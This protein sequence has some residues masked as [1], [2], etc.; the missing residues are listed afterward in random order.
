MEESI[1]RV[2]EIV[3]ETDIDKRPQLP[4]IRQSRTAKFALKTANKAVQNI[5]RWLE[6]QLSLAEVN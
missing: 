3:K 2:M 6:Q 1:L 5:K 4:K